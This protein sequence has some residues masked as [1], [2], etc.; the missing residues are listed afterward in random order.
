MKAS[1]L[2]FSKEPPRVEEL[3]ERL[4]LDNAAFV[5]NLYH[6]VLG[7]QPSPP[8]SA[9]WVLRMNTGTSRQQAAMSFWQSGEHRKLEVTQFYQLYLHRSPDGPGATAWQ[10]A[11]AAGSTE[12][13]VEAGILTSA[14]YRNLHNTDTAYVDALYTDVLGRSPS[15]S[16][17]A[18]WTSRLAQNGAAGVV[19][20]IVNATENYRRIVDN[21]FTSYLGRSADTSGESFW[22]AALESSNGN[23]EKVAEAMLS[24]DEYFALGVK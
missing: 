13:Q 24:S 5:N 20:G 8:E 21:N 7:R 17:E 19:S 3:E 9:S 15:A 6:D 16:D 1:G 2:Q 14:E 4:V 23:V 12:L 22:T 10:N 18:F 11:L